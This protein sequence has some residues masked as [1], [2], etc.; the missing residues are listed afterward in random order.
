MKVQFYLKANFF[1][2]TVSQ[3]NIALF[4]DVPCE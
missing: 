3:S 4:I 1:L 2:P